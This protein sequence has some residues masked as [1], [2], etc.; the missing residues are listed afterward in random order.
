MMKT[1]IIFMLLTVVAMCSQSAFAQEKK[2]PDREQ[3]QAMQCNQVV[4]A[5]MLDD[6]TAAKFVPVYQKYLKELSEVR[7]ENARKPK[8]KDAVTTQPAPKAIPTDAE[9]EKAIKDRFAQSRKLLDIREKYY[10]EFRKIL[11]PKQIMKIYQ[12]EKGNAHKFQKEW[13]KR[14]GQKQ[15]QRPEAKKGNMHRGNNNVKSQK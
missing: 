14:Q 13:K 1:R 12:L 7:M 10:N 9:V 15:G 2:R 4:K 11:S 8:V 3:I 5:L 6:A